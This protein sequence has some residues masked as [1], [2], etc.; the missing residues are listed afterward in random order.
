MDRARGL[1]RCHRCTTTGS[2]VWRQP[3]AGNDAMSME[4]RYFTSLFRILPISYV[5]MLSVERLHLGSRVALASSASPGQRVVDPLQ[6]VRRQFNSKRTDV[7][8]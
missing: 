2:L 4:K 7:L 3:H 6:I 5:L 8:L 1:H